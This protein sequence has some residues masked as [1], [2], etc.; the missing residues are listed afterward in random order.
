M[1]E[2]PGQR[3][4]ARRIPTPALAAALFIKRGDERLGQRYMLRDCPHAPAGATPKQL[5]ARAASGLCP[6]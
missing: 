6:A 5:P 4:T 3:P 2:I 1:S